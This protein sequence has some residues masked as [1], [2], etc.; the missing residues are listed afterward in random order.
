MNYVLSGVAQ[1][2]GLWPADF[3]SPAADLWLTGDY[4]VGKLSSMG[5]PTRPTQPSVPPWSVNE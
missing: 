5:H 4:F 3:P 2:F 1:W